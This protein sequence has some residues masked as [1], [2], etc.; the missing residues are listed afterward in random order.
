MMEMEIMGMDAVILDSRKQGKVSC[1]CFLGIFDLTLIL[2][3]AVY[4]SWFLEG[5]LSDL[6][7]K[8]ATMEILSMEMAEA[9]HAL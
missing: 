1:W 4:D 7:V 6:G 5:I 8:D 3:W 2:L 9:P